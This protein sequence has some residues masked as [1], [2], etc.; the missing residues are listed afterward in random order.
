[1]PAETTATGVTRH[2][3]E[4]GGDVEAGGRAA[5][6]AADAA[7]GEHPDAGERGDAHGGRHGG[8]AGGA[9]WRPATAG[10]GWWPCARPARWPG[11]RSCSG[12]RPTQHTP[13]STAM[14]A[15]VAPLARTMPSTSVAICTFCG[16]GMPWLMMVLSS[17][18]TGRPAASAS[19]T[20]GRTD[21][22]DARSSVIGLPN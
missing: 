2:L 4:V 10:R 20:S 3:G 12:E 22:F 21:R 9:A 13:S 15:G 19:A 7:G 17:A 18:T 16:Y 11:A 8:G 6:H 5:V 1:M 14:V